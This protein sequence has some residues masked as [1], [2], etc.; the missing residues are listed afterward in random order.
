MLGCSQKQLREAAKEFDA[1][2]FK[3]VNVVKSPADGPSD[4][5]EGR[6]F[7]VYDMNYYEDEIDKFEW[8]FKGELMLGTIKIHREFLPCQDRISKKPHDDV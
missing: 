3:V 1:S 4:S 8:W 2:K 5:V 6:E 7:K